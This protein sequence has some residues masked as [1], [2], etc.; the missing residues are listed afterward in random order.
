MN[1]TS[2]ETTNGVELPRGG[3]E[4][5]GSAVVLVTWTPANDPPKCKKTVRP[6]K[7]SGDW[8]TRSSGGEVR[9]PIRSSGEYISRTNGNDNWDP[10]TTPVNYE[11][12]NIAIG[13]SANIVGV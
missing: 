8:S 11:A 2:S 4:D 13:C 6:P 3:L 1:S 7:T 12:S 10:G 5:N 9:E